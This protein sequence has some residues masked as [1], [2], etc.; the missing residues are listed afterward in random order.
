MAFWDRWFRRKDPYQLERRNIN[1]PLVV[2]A[3]RKLSSATNSDT[4]MRVA[5]V[6]ACQ[7]IIAEGV[8][9]LPLFLYRKEGRNKF[10][11][12]E[13]PLYEALHVLPNPEMTAFGLR[14]TMMTRAVREGNAFAQIV[15]NGFGQVIEL[16]PLVN[17]YMRIERDANSDLL[18]VWTRMDGS[19]RYFRVH[20]ILHL[21]GLSGDGI[22]GYSP[23]SEARNSFETATVMDEYNR[24][25]YENG[26]RPSG[27]LE[28][29]ELLDNGAAE[30]MRKSW[31]EMNGGVKNAG[32]IAVLEQGTKYTPINIA[33]TDQQYIEQKKLSREEIASIFRVPAH[34]LN[35]LD[36]ATFASV[37]EMSQEFIDY[38]LTPWLVQWEQT[39]YKDLL[40]VSE[41]KIYYAKHAVQALLRGNNDSRAKFYATGIQWGWTSVNE[42]RELE[43]LNAIADGDQY[44]MQLNMT[45]LE[46]IGQ[47][48]Q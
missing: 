23:I 18:Y 16:Y 42:V 24:A 28:S 21:R 1:S 6:Y 14:S 17:G 44:F 47:P 5:T 3:I 35:A 36:R 32:K 34:M 11:A 37:E 31:E 29:P 4:A 46:R 13:L 33:Q 41:R 38:T 26:G 9:M 7:K 15:R 12:S 2:D 39:I 20:E 25:F 43:D 27:V 8:A 30:R 45:T 40:S 22:V 19:R 10:P 48:A